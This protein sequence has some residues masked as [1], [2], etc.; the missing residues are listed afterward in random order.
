MKDTVDLKKGYTEKLKTEKRIKK[1]VTFCINF[2]LVIE[3]NHITRLYIN[4]HSYGSKIKTL[5]MSYMQTVCICH[6]VRPQNV[7]F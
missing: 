2:N 5:L 4:G 7:Y 6:Y 3:Y 1:M